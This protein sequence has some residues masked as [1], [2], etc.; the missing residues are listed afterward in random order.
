MPLITLVK[1]APSGAS[2]RV[3]LAV[4]CGGGQIHAPCVAS[5]L[6]AQPVLMAAGIAVDICIE[7]GNCHVD[8]ARNSLVR[9]FIRSDCTDM[10]FI[11]ADVGFLAQDLLTLVTLDRDLVAGVYPKKQEPDD[12]PV[13]TAHGVDL[14][15]EADGCVEVLGAPTGFMRMSRAMLVS[16]TAYYKD[17]SFAGQQAKDGD[18]LYTLLFEREIAEGR[19]WSGDYNFC[20]RWRA[21]GGKV[22]VDPRMQFVHEGLRQWK[23]CLGDHWRK[24]HGVADLIKERAFDAAL[25]RCK[26]G[27]PTAS[28]FHVLADGWGNGAWAASPTFCAA[29]YALARQAD[30]PILECGS[31]LTTLVMAAA[32]AEVHVLEH[33]PLYAM[34]VRDALHEHGLSVVY[35]VGA[36]IDGWYQ[37][38]PL[39]QYNLVVID[40][41]PRAISDR[42]KAYAYA[43]G[44]VLADDMQDEA[45]RAALESWA[46]DRAVKMA[47]CGGKQFAL[48]K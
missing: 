29:A 7:A 48:V 10:V 17:R 19:R 13:M 24:V 20:R 27:T 18:P 43:N 21:M 38:P 39:A 9:E 41:P 1:G 26:A 30:G 37:S 12:F 34:K 40:G 25:Q 22:Y 8:D 36:L 44:A 3:F 45:Q 14:R 47:E 23:G 6:E 5:L 11:D 31:G 2:Q 16:M 4:P 28:D 42:S 32:G 35:R 33:D 46:A 15:A